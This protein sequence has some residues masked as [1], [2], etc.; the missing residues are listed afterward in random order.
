MFVDNDRNFM[1]LRQDLISVSLLGLLRGKCQRSNRLVSLQVLNIAQLLPCF[2][3]TLK[4][5]CFLC[6]TLIRC[7]TKFNRQIYRDN[8]RDQNNA[9]QDRNQYS[10]IVWSL[11]TEPRTRSVWKDELHAGL[12]LCSLVF[13]F[14]APGMK[15]REIK[16]NTG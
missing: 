13:S 6:N 15:L 10:D 7:V 2:L 14:I 5:T 11:N 4:K 12:E 3:I 16:K 1:A 8:K 9:F